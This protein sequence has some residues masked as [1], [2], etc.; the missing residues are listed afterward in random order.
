M[1]SKTKF[2]WSDDDF[3]E[4]KPSRLA[5]KAADVVSPPAKKSKKA[6]A[7]EPEPEPEPIASSSKDWR[8]HTVNDDD[9]DFVNLPS[10]K[11]AK[12]SNTP[13]IVIADDGDVADDVPAAAAAAKKEKDLRVIVVGL[14]THLLPANGLSADTMREWF[15]TECSEVGKILQLKSEFL[16]FLLASL[17]AKYNNAKSDTQRQAAFADLPALAN[18][19]CH[20]KLTMAVADPGCN[21]SPFLTQWRAQLPENFAFPSIKNRSRVIGFS[22]TEDATSFI[23]FF[24]TTIYK[25]MRKLV[26]LK[27][28]QWNIDPKFTNT[29]MDICFKGEQFPNDVPFFVFCLV[30]KFKQL[31]TWN[32]CCDNWPMTGGNMK[33]YPERFLLLQQYLMEE[34]EASQGK[35]KPIPLGPSRGF[36]AP[37]LHFDKEGLSYFLSAHHYPNMPTTKERRKDTSFIN[38]FFSSPFVIDSV[39]TNGTTLNV[40]INIKT[41]QKVPKRKGNKTKKKA[42]QKARKEQRKMIRKFAKSGEIPMVNVEKMAKKEE[43]KEMLNKKKT[44][45]QKKARREAVMKMQEEKEEK[46][47]EKEEKEKEKEKEKKK[48]KKGKKK[49]SEEEEESKKQDQV[50][51]VMEYMQANIHAPIIG[52]DIVFFFLAI[53]YTFAD[54]PIKCPLP[55]RSSAGRSLGTSWR[56]SNAQWRNLTGMTRTNYVIAKWK[57]NAGI[58]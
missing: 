41:K 11:K 5:E 15:E 39:S 14:Q 27:L 20:Y 4:P 8:K 42:N 9:N 21:S 13:P 35:L 55:V 22:S 23:N 51:N 29:I 1:G 43:K 30:R 16:L 40:Y 24:S 56:L 28:T 32:G 34:Y 18:S 52:L 17:L 58:N 19:N 49:K 50:K 6:K 31:A 33:K 37:Y 57:K 53:E 44:K 45:E 38:K 25:R 10:A 48:E 12:P 46:K 7:P 26:N 36:V 2:A 3:Q 54:L 47:K